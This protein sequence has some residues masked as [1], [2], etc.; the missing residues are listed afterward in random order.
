[1]SSS[2]FIFSN[3]RKY[4]ISRHVSFWV[5]WWVFQGVLYS[6]VTTYNSPLYWKRLTMSMA[7]SLAFLTMH[8]FL[9]YSLMYFVIPRFLLRQRYWQTAAYT[10]LLF[11]L[12][13]ILSVVIGGYFIDPL[14]WLMFGDLF[15]NM[16][17]STS[18]NIF[19]LTSSR[20]RITRST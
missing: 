19:W 9:A 7:E 15:I 18:S 8:I 11:L 13:A 17:S 4:R 16:Y 10:A 20:I 2:P 1:M 3:E 14:R 6:F 5:F 12:T